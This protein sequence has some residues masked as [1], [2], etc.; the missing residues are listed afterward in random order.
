LREGGIKGYNKI[1]RIRGVDE[2]GIKDIKVGRDV[3]N[4]S[5]YLRG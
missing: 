4:W 1:V 3:G 2:S 5:N